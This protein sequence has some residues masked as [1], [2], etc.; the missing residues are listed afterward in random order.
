M[1]IYDKVKL[2]KEREEYLKKRLNLGKIGT[3]IQP[4][5]RDNRFPL[6]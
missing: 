3:I 4:E 1:K 2:I 6:C 5:I